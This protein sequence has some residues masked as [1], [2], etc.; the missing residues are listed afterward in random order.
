[1]SAGAVK[2]ARPKLTRNY[3]LDSGVRA[4]TERKARAAAAVNL[5]RPVTPN[6]GIHLSPRRYIARATMEYEVDLFPS[7]GRKAV[8]VSTTN[9]IFDA[10]QWLPD[11]KIPQLTAHV[12]APVRKM[13]PP[14]INV[15]SE[16][17]TSPAMDVL[18][19]MPDA[20]L[21]QVSNFT[22]RHAWFGSIRFLQPV[23]LRGLQID[24]IVHFSSRSIE[25]Y[26]EDCPVTKPARGHGLNQ[27]AEV[28]LAGCHPKKGKSAS[29]YRAKL[30]RFCQKN[31]MM[32]FIGYSEEKGEWSFAV[33][34]F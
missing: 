13:G 26:G 17:T 29:N 21:V 8:T 10:T 2:I 18:Q 6:T 31:P 4:V 7:G 22:I 30:E 32:Q 11:P 19:R 1:L 20:E 15:S 28:V 3:S 9:E 12:S 14:R 23:D 25:V 34:G 33:D 27:P 5:R 24:S 16:L